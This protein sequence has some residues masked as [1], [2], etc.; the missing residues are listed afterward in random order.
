MHSVIEFFQ[1][2]RNWVFHWLA[3]T[4]MLAVMCGVIVIEKLLA[5]ADEP[6]SVADISSCTML[7]YRSRSSITVQCG[8]TQFSLDVDTDFNNRLLKV[9]QTQAVLRFVCNQD[10]SNSLHCDVQP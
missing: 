6:I 3:T 1:D 2:S 7:N 9:A 10:S 5:S 4:I 8:N